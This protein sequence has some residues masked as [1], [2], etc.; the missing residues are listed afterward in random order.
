MPG[1]TQYVETE[2]CF[3]F[4]ASLGQDLAL[5]ARPCSPGDYVENPSSWKQVMGGSQL[6][7][8]DKGSFLLHGEESCE[9]RLTK[10][11]HQHFLPF[12]KE[13]CRQFPVFFGPDHDNVGL[14]AIIHLL[15]LE[16]A[17]K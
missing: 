2:P 12:L 16:Q 6:S 9:Y 10:Q 15:P 3:F 14:R 5:L 8:L 4:M 7:L 11:R 1:L 17:G 13:I